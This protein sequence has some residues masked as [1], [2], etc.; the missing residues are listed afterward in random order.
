MHDNVHICV[1]DKFL[2]IMIRMPVFRK[3]KCSSLLEVFPELLRT[4]TEAIF[5]LTNVL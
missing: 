3:I 5:C 4:E 1:F 2:Y